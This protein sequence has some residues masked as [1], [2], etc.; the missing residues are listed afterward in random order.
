MIE[1]AAIF[2]AITPAEELRLEKLLTEIAPWLPLFG[3][4][5]YAHVLVFFYRNAGVILALGVILLL[6]GALYPR[7]LPGDDDK[8]NIDF[9]LGIVQAKIGGNAR[10]IIQ[11][12]GL[13]IIAGALLMIL[14][15]K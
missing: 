6:F 10:T 9:G 13:L 5:A 12:G 14:T 1:A 3:V 4:A 8:N 11:A 2:A 15:T 7:K